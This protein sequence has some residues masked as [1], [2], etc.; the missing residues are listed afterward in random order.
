M[1][2]VLVGPAQT[3]ALAAVWNRH[4][5]YTGH[6]TPTANQTSS[7]MSTTLTV[8]QLHRNKYI[9]FVNKKKRDKPCR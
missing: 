2:T 8:T 1:T 6:Q 5:H 3:A 7:K 9:D 4:R